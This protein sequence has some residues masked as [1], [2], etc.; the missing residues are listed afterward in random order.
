MQSEQQPHGS[1]NSR[2][3]D[4]R[5]LCLGGP[6][7]RWPERCRPDSRLA[8]GREDRSTP[9]R[10]LN[11]GRRNSAFPIPARPAAGSGEAGQTER[12]GPDSF[13]N[14]PGHDPDKEQA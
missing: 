6:A 11:L 5:R 3:S 1:A 7:P 2:W 8:A 12:D 14:Q 10:R 9:R 13:I 4:W